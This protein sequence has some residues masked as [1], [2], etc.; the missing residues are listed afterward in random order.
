MKRFYEKAA[1]DE[2]DD[3]HVV[4]LDGRPIQ[5]PARNRLVLPNRGFAEAVAAEWAAQ[6]KKVD[7]AAMP[8][9]RLAGIAVDD[10]AHRTGA[11]VAAIA[12]YGDTDLTC[13]RAEAPPDLAA[14]QHRHWQPLLDWIAARHGVALTTVVGVTPIRQPDASLDA[15][16]RAVATD[17][18]FVLSGVHAA[19]ACCGSVVIAVA[20][21]DGEIDADAAW[22]AAQVDEDYQ[23]ETWGVDDEAAERRRNIRADLEATARLLELCAAG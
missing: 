4:T 17:D 14:R 20:L 23:I 8:L 11:V 12:A 21:R 2:T 10:V 13:Y 15:L 5:S 9:M 3:G 7:F 16:R 18:P 22:A 19:T 1:A 6:G